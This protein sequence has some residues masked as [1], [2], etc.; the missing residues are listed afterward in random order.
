MIDGGDAER[1]DGTLSAAL[2]KPL[3][4]LAKLRQNNIPPGM[5]H[6]LPQGYTDAVF[7]FCS[8]HAVESMRRTRSLALMQ[9]NAFRLA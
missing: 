3:D 2:L 8:H 6:A 1:Q 5:R 7:S 9:V 4:A